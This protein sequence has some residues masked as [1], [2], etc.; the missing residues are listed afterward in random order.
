MFRRW[1]VVGIVGLALLTCWGCKHDLDRQRPCTDACPTDASTDRPVD[2]PL[3]D[4]LDK[5]TP[6]DVKVTDAGPIPKSTKGA[7]IKGGWCWM[8]PLPQG[9]DLRGVWAASSSEAYAVGE[10]GTLLRLTK[11]GQW[12]ALDCGTLKHLNAVWG[13]S[14]TSVWAVG[15]SGTTVWTDGKT[16]T[17][18]TAGTTNTLNGIWGHS[19]NAIYAVGNKGGIYFNGGM[20]F[21]GWSTCGAKDLNAAWGTGASDLYVV[22]DSGT[23]V[24]LLG[25]TCNTA[26]PVTTDNLNAV[27]GS[28]ATDIHAVGTQGEV[29]HYTGTWKASQIANVELLSVWGT[30]PS[31]V[32]AAGKDGTLYHLGAKWQ[33][34]TSPT[35]LPVHAVYGAGSN[36]HAVGDQG[37][38]LRRK[39][40]SWILTSTLFTGPK[41]SILSIRG[42]SPTDIMATG[43]YGAA[44]RFDGKAWSPTAAGGT[45][46]ALQGVWAAGGGTYW[47][48]GYKYSGF[49]AVTLYFNGTTWANVVAPF[50]SCILYDIWGTGNQ[51]FAT[52]GHP[53]NHTL[54]ILEK[55]GTAAWKLIQPGAKSTGHGVWGR[56][57]TDVY[58]AGISNTVLHRDA[59]GWKPLASPSGTYIGY[60]SVWGTGP[61]T[62]FF[63][64]SSSGYGYMMRLQG[65]FW[66]GWALYRPMKAAWGTGPTDVYAVGGSGSLYRFEGVQWKGEAIGTGIDLM[67]I[68]GT[69]T[70]NVYIAGSGGAILHRGK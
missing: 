54:K 36:V 24:H 17:K 10:H 45:T 61:S 57:A 9:H 19:A 63:P 44:L 2:A 68:W 3:A 67:D 20:G 52:G 31:D 15:D 60:A 27:W 46:H 40:G 30:G 51:V 69:S 70:T 48:A 28:G 21:S 64:G 50:P 7:C 35:K 43:G 23:V 1:S 13:S 6:G 39:A 33:S 25:K 8:H 32:H 42:N 47:A 56:S 62:V 14:P 41:A 26:T 34:V 29:L 16:C 11:A 18:I 53:G 58:V 59:T 38:M 4:L 65:G 22:G 55:T 5:G 37:T 49:G 66:K 12:E